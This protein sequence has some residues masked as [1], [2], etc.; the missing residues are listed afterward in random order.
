MTDEKA[1]DNYLLWEL[2]KQQDIQ[3]KIME[4]SPDGEELKEIVEKVRQEY[5]E[6]DY[7]F[8]EKLNRL[9][10]LDSNPE[11]RLEVFKE[12]SWTKETVKM[13]KLGTTLPRAGDLPPEVMTGTLPEV[14]EWVKKADPEDYRSVKYIRSLSKVPEIL[15][16]F[17]PWVIT[18][19]SRSSKRDRM[20]K[21]HGEEDWD[22]EDT[23]GMIN[24]GNHRTIAKIIANGSE[25]I[26]CY[27]GRPK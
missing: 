13:E 10:E 24:D 6:K 25:E 26:E 9:Q 27:V 17:P 15:N 1:I 7:R 8:E 12:H 23:W 18:P 3:K 19:G 5:Q 16:E 11:Y 21:V 20:N 4:G 2:C 22:I 14:V